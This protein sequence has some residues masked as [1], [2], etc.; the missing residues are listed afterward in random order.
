MD[1]LSAQVAK[2]F[3]GVS[4]NGIM[5][6]CYPIHVGSIPTA[7]ANFGMIV[8]MKKGRSLEHPIVRKMLVQIHKYRQFPQATIQ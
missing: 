3:V 5:L 1:V 7:P 4:Y 6:G 2:L 8:Q